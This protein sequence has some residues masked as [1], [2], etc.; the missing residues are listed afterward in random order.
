MQIFRKFPSKY[1]GLIKDVIAKVDE[2]Y[3]VE[4]KSA[5]IW[6]IGEYAE[7]IKESEKLIEKF[8]QN[9]LEDPDQ[10]KLQL[11]TSTV[12]LYLKK[13]DNSESLI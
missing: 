13:P 12:K 3:E 4:A 6:I 7:K 2:Y 8:S 10:V 5:V 1:E 9:F 11:V